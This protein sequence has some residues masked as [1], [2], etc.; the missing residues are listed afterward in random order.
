MNAGPEDR[1]LRAKVEAL[2]GYGVAPASIA[3]VLGLSEVELRATYAEQIEASAIKANAKVA[4]NLFRKATGDGREAVTA[5]IFWLKAR[6]GWKE[7][8]VSEVS[9]REGAAIPI[10]YRQAFRGLSGEERALVRQ[11]IENRARASGCT[12][13]GERVERGDSDG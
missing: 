9:G 13:D 10:E 2:A 3:R 7:T 5:A 6:A 1:P 4:E 11:M 8:L 12:I